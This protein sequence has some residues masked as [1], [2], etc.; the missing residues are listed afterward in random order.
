MAV[1]TL[2]DLNQHP[3]IPQADLFDLSSQ[4]KLNS[5]V[6]RRT[7]VE[8]KTPPVHANTVSGRK[9]IH[10]DAVLHPPT[11][12]PSI[13]VSLKYK[14][15]SHKSQT[16]ASPVTHRRMPRKKLNKNP[17]TTVRAEGICLNITH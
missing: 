4:M 6:D 9:V 2:W 3:L 16:L 10:L 5:K 14:V 15:R 7:R 12:K 11:F 1:E 13:L 17:S 8:G